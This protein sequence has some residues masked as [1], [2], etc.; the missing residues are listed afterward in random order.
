MLGGSD[1]IVED[2]GES[3]KVS[4]LHDDDEASSSSSHLRPSA[5]TANA[6][7]TSQSGGNAFR[8]GTVKSST[9]RSLSGLSLGGSGST[10]P[11]RIGQPTEDPIAETSDKSNRN[12]DGSAAED[13]ETS[14]PLP[15]GGI[16]TKKLRRLR[17]RRLGGDQEAREEDK[18]QLKGEEEGKEGGKDQ[19]KQVDGGEQEAPQSLGEDSQQA[20]ELAV[21]ERRQGGDAAA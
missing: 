20:V 18:E 13:N 17:S 11:P 16:L 21:E 9:G 8:M 15:R 6:S 5:D 4:S 2:E 19:D 14:S 3:H 12:D 10:S 7:A 1:H